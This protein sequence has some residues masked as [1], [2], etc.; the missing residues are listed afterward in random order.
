[1]SSFISM[2]LDTYDPHAQDSQIYIPA[3]NSFLT[4]R[5]IYSVACLTYLLECLTYISKTKL[6]T[7]LSSSQSKQVNL[8]ENERQELYS[9]GFYL[10]VKKPL[11][12]ILCS[13]QNPGRPWL[14][15]HFPSILSLPDSIIHHQDELNLPPNIS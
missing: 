1:M 4:F 7:L 13:N 15:Y 8:T 2:T 11:L 12:L 9:S 10:A 14:T 5:L 3:L 6:T